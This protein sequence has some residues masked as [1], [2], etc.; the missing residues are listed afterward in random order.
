MIFLRIRSHGKLPCCSTIW[1]N[2]KN[3][4]YSFQASFF[5]SP[6]QV[7]DVKNVEVEV[8]AHINI[9]KSRWIVFDLVYGGWGF[10]LYPG[11]HC[12]ISRS[13]G[14]LLSSQNQ[15]TK[16]PECFRTWHRQKL[17]WKAGMPPLP[18]IIFS[19]LE[20]HPRICKFSGFSVFITNGDS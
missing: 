19:H 18:R 1:E 9:S 16:T 8:G 3:G 12:F 14:C 10:L 17:L 2:M 20:V 5:E 15:K 6:I 11:F 13:F 4:T 7:L